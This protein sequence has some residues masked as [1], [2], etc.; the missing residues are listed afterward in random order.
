MTKLLFIYSV[1]KPI[2]NIQQSMID[3]LVPIS[4]VTIPLLQLS[5]KTLSKKESTMKFHF[6]KTI[7]GIYIHLIYCLC[8]SISPRPFFLGGHEPYYWT[9]CLTPLKINM[10][11]TTGGRS[12]SCHAPFGCG[13]WWWSKARHR[14]DESCWAA[15]GPTDC[16]SLLSALFRERTKDNVIQTI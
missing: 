13:W 1:W 6:K 7:C 11:L 8:L 3:N 5:K 2:G 14:G 12:S 15:W 4:L 10:V 9:F 16:F